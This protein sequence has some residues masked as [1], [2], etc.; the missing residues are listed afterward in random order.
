MT[1]AVKECKETKVVRAW[2]TQ[3]QAA[4]EMDSYAGKRQFPR[5]NWQE[6]I[7][8]KV[9]SR[10]REE[11]VYAKAKNI[12]LGGAGIFARQ[13]VAPGTLV[14]V[15]AGDHPE[16]V[17]ARVMHCTVTLGG[18]L[19]GLAFEVDAAEPARRAG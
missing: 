10:R 11:L 14:E 12:S 16:C 2:L 3:A 9:H 17:T 7:V 5:Y 15:W 1:A 6:T 18:F 13:R 19:V 4:G 8:M